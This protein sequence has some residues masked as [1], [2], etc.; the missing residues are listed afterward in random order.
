MNGAKNAYADL[1]NPDIHG[2]QECSHDLLLD[3]PSDPSVSCIFSYVLPN[4]KKMFMFFLYIVSTL[5]VRESAVAAELAVEACIRQTQWKLYSYK[6]FT[7]G[8][9]CGSSTRFPF[10]F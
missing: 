6:A 3:V 8:R 7:G 1:A 5:S 9:P 4:A 2:L 10:L